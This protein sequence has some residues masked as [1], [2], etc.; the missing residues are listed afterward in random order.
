MAARKK[1]AE[2]GRKKAPGK[3]KP[4]RKKSPTRKK[5]PAREKPA[6]LKKTAIRKK[7]ALRKKAAPRKK[8]AARKTVTKKVSPKKASPK[9]RAARVA[10][11]N[12]P[13]TRRKAVRRKV[14][15]S[16]VVRASRQ[17]P[18]S[19]SI[20]SPKASTAPNTEIVVS[21]A[22]AS[23]DKIGVIQHYYPRVEAAIINVSHGV[24]RTGDTLHFRGHTTDFYQRVDRMEVEHQPVEAVTAGQAVGV[25]VSRRVREGDLVMRVA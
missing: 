1:A 21:V 15:A 18:T 16:K 11:T 4:I 22:G 7:A 20:E 9:K 19:Q 17:K 6:V 2:R 24:L 8:T 23:A 12:Q 5:P 25:H 14:A 13:A 3:K 10:R